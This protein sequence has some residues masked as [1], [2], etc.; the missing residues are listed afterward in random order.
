MIETQG[1]LN[2]LG[3]G[4]LQFE[5]LDDP[6]GPVRLLGVNE[7]HEVEDVMIPGETYTDA[8]TP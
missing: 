7:V 4:N 2:R 8:P 5:I 6:G 1:V 3:D